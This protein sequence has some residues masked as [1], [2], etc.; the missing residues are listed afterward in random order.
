MLSTCDSSAELVTCYNLYNTHFWAYVMY[1]E[2]LQ[3]TYRE[4]LS[5]DVNLL[6]V[7]FARHIRQ[8][9]TTHKIARTVIS[10]ALT[11]IPTKTGVSIIDFECNVVPTPSERCVF[12][13]KTYSYIHIHIFASK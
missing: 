7:C 9:Q 6:C 8:V 5:T 13:A 2:L 4:E 1:Y 3:Y 12:P 11:L 10:S